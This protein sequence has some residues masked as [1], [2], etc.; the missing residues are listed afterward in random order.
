[1]CV[2]CK[3]KSDRIPIGGGLKVLSRRTT[4]SEAVKILDDH[5]SANRTVKKNQVTRL[6]NDMRSG[7]WVPNSGEFISFDADNVIVSGQH[8]LLAS[9]ESGVAVDLWFVFG[10]ETAARI[11][12]DAAAKRSGHDALG[13]SGAED[14]TVLQAAALRIL[15]AYEAGYIDH[16]G[17]RASRYN[18]TNAHLAEHYAKHSGLSEAAAWATKHARVLSTIPTSCVA[19]GY[20]VTHRI[21]AY[22]AEEFWR[23]LGDGNS[24]DS[25]DP[26]LAMLNMFRSVH[27]RKSHNKVTGVYVYGISHAWNLW[28]KDQ[29]VR[30]MSYYTTTEVGDSRVEKFRA[31]PQLV[32]TA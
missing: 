18:V 1:M 8:R 24:L 12:C 21:D 2:L 15:L 13:F 20:Y 32:E 11:V 26:R 27:H 29:T 7:R 16:S 23:E 4:P 25:G 22:W 31:V 5:N 28:I 19:W 9:V 3:H 6:A 14:Y 10:V 30:A 17:K